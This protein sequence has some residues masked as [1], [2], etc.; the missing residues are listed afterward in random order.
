MPALQARYWLLTIPYECFTP[1]LPGDCSWIRGQF[2]QGSETGYLHWQVFVAFKAK[3]TL[4]RVKLLF[5]DVIHAEHAKS[6]KAQEYVF[7]EDTR[8]AGTQLD[9]GKKPM[10]RTSSKDWDLIVDSARSGDFSTIP[11]DVL[12]RC[13]GNLKKIRVDSLKPVAQE[14][15]V[16]VFW[17]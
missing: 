3:C 13:Y 2:E 4:T 14:K 17:G 11:G 5:G 8:V 6:K 12:V 16:H 15:I 7:K 10:D 1:Y 9:L